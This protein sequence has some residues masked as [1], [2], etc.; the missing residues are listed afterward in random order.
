[1]KDLFFRKKL[2]WRQLFITAEFFD[3]YVRPHFVLN[4]VLL[5]LLLF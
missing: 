5:T 2:K 3:I 1:M 4:Q